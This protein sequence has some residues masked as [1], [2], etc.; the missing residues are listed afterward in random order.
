LVTP[1]PAA[2]AFG[3]QRT[4]QLVK[5]VDHGV[6][7][8][9]LE[10]E[11]L[12]SERRSP[13]KTAEPVDHVG[14]CH[15]TLPDKLAEAAFMDGGGERGIETYRPDMIEPGEHGDEA[16]RRHGFRDGAQPSQA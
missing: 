10:L 13:P 15:S 3:E 5:Q 12:S 11:D 7:Q 1:L 16:R 4:H 9:S 2:L 14:R 8:A 6:G